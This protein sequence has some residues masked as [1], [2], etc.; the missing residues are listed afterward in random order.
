MTGTVEVRRQ[1]TRIIDPTAWRVLSF[2]DWSRWHQRTFALCQQ[3]RTVIGKW[4]VKRN[5]A[6][7]YR[8]TLVSAPRRGRPWAVGRDPQLREGAVS[9]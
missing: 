4:A 7:V 1:P 3:A 2:L 5:S 9:S 6:S 8:R